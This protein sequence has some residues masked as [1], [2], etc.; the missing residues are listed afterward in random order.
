MG[1]ITL[2]ERLF[3]Q[4]ESPVDG[5]RFLSLRR[6]FA[7]QYSD[8]NWNIRFFLDQILTIHGQGWL[9]HSVPSNKKT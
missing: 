9:F 8:H 6:Y 7:V 3:Q 1:G 5:S 2:T 4:T